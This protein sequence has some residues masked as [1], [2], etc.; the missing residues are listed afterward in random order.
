MALFNLDS[1]YRHFTEVTEENILK[2]IL[3]EYFQLNHKKI[4][5]KR[6]LLFYHNIIKICNFKTKLLQ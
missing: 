2:I 4:S 3:Y 6:L 1:T 5:S